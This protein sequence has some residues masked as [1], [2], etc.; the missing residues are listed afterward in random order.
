M[1]IRPPGRADKT[2]KMEF[3]CVALKL[4]SKRLEDLW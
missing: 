1:A 3:K 4:V 2:K